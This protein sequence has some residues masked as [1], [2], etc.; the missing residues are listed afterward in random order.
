MKD[1]IGKRVIDYL[2]DKKVDTTPY[3]DDF[4][5]EIITIDYFICTQCSLILHDSNSSKNDPDL[6]KS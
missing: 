6:W 4:L 3:S 1:Y 2:N 5:K